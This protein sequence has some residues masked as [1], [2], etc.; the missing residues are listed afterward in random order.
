LSTKK[1]KVQ[2]QNVVYISCPSQL[3]SELRMLMNAKVTS[4]HDR[5]ILLRMPWMTDR[6]KDKGIETLKQNDNRIV[7]IKT[8]DGEVMIAKVRFVS[9][10]NQDLIYD[11]VSN[12][13]ESQY[14]KPDEQPGQR[15]AFEDIESVEAVDL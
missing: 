3:A 5:F 2:L 1:N 14:E 4:I 15:I 12:N 11:L 6:T 8:Y 13:K 7:R 10:S 9:D